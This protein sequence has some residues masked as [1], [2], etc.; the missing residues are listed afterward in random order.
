MQKADILS[1]GPEGP[2]VLFINRDEFHYPT[3]H[4]LDMVSKYYFQ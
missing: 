2:P 4:L 3:I 1:G